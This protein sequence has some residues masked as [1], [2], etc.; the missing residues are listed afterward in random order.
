MSSKNHTAALLPAQGS[1][2]EVTQRPTPTPGPRELLIE[3]KSIA[4]NPVDWKQRD[5]GFALT[6]Y[7]AVLGSDVAG[8]VLSVGSD[9]PSEFKEGTR[10]AAFAPTFFKGGAADYGAFQT[11]VLVPSDNAV[12]L[13]KGMSFNEGSLLPMA[14]VTPWCGWYS[15][16]LPYAT[17]FK[18]ADKKGMLIW[19]GAS[20]IG[21]AAVQIAKLMGFTVYA[22]ASEKN[23]PYVKSLGASHVFDYR[24]EDVV[25]QIVKAAKADG[26]TVSMAFDAAGQLKD[27]MDVLAQTKGQGTAKVAS[28]IPLMG[29]QPKVEGVEAKFVLPPE[30]EEGRTNHFHFVFN[31]WLNE[32]LEKEEFVPNPKIQ[33]IGNGLESIQVGLDTLKKGVSGTK[34]V[35]EM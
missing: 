20:C 32:K 17:A 34:L 2:L 11:R 27:I 30:G 33:V 21:G 12:P 28:A 4:L 14:V 18:P 22:T 16:G 10:I 6:T 5:F 29:E 35:V 7:P 24:S 19:G 26:I 3:V 8:S 31:V 1:A 9:V 23:H 15:I 13:P 25:T